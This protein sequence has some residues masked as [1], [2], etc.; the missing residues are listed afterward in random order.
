MSIG[1]RFINLARSELNSL[2]DKA[3]E[4]DVD[5]KDDDGDQPSDDSAFATYSDAELE[6]E[7]QRRKTEREAEARARKQRASAPPR[8]TAAAGNDIR[9]A[10]MALE[11][12]E[13]SDFGTVKKA[14]RQLMRK[15]HPDRHQRA[16]EKQQAAHELTQR[17][18]DAY[19][20]LKKHLG[21]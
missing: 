16:P 20:R 7:L 18:T 19:N 13:G 12:P 2:L 11:L 9:K 4:I 5:D 15:Y 1:R 8:A 21:G 14:Y 17:L 3:R 6:K 10:Y